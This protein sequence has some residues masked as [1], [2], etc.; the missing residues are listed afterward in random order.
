[1]KS[2]LII[3]FLILTMF[4][5]SKGQ[6]NIDF[7]IS[8]LSDEKVKLS[9]IYS[10]GPT[11]VTFWALW[12]KP[13]RAEMK[14]LNELYK[15]YFSQGFN[16]LAINQD[17]QRSS[18]KVKS[19]VE[20]IGVEY[21]VALDLNKEFSEMFNVQVI[22]LSFLFDRNGKIVYRH[23]GYL[24]GDEHGLEEEVKKTLNEK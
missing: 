12:C 9:E 22:P 5:Q 14:I 4:S 11:L 21:M 8:L 19:F 2:K 24:P 20:S 3:I 17:T 15:K 16:I 18:E 1:M 10:S 23:T 6:N 13:C 7:S